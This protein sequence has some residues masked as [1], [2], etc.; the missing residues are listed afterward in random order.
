MALLLLW[1]SFTLEASFAGPNTGALAG[2]PYDTSQLE[3]IGANLAL[4]LLDY[5]DPLQVSQALAHLHKAHRPPPQPAAAAAAG[6]EQCDLESSGSL[7]DEAAMV[8]G[9]LEFSRHP[10]YAW[11]R[12]NVHLTLAIPVHACNAELPGLTYIPWND[13]MLTGAGIQCCRSSCGLTEPCHSDRH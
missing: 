10:A 7:S 1:C 12:Q 9:S 3:T 6:Q 11:L 13:N 4:A 8:S 2:R 5:S